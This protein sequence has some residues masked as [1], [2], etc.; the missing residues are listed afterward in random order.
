M[1]IA[2]TAP[3][4]E[5]PV[6][7]RGRHCTYTDDLAEEICERIGN[8]D[9]LRK[10]GSDP[11]MPSAATICRWV[12]K[13]PEF[14]IMYDAALIAK[15]DERTKDLEDI[16]ADAKNDYDVV[17]PAAENA[18]PTVRLN[19]EA[20]ERSKLRVSVLQWIMAKELPHKYGEA[21]PQ[22]VIIAPPAPIVVAAANPAQPAQS[23]S[24]LRLVEAEETFK[25]NEAAA[26]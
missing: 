12:G 1:S 16:A 13:Y 24:Y 22:Q 8:G 26:R 14:K 25:A 9:T 2:F 11:R 18:I 19:K 10:I 20:I 6:S 4:T 17:A 5:A 21:V 23:P 7:R 3:A 15:F